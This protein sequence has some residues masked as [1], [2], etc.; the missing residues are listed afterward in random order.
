MKDY[1]NTADETFDSLGRLLQ[2]IEDAII[3][4]PACGSEPA[5]AR[6]KEKAMQQ[7]KALCIVHEKFRPPYESKFIDVVG[8][9]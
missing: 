8:L 2:Q 6:A 5:E 4:W 3:D 7:F 1:K 9:N